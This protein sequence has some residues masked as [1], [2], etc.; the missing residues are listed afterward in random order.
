MKVQVLLRDDLDREDPLSLMSRAYYNPSAHCPKITMNRLEKD[1]VIRD[2][3]DSADRV[4]SRSRI[5]DAVL[6]SI[7]S[8][9][10]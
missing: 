5:N 4:Q 6:S 7:G 3:L 1:L 8:T 9:L 2:D 10:D